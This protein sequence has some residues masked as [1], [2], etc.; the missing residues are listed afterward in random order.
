MVVNFPCVSM[1]PVPPSLLVPSG[2]A[3]LAQRPPLPW[4]IAQALPE[5]SPGQYHSRPDLWRTAPAPFGET[6][7]KPG[8]TL[9]ALGRP[10]IRSSCPPAS[11]SPCVVE[12]GPA[13]PATLPWL[14]PVS[15]CTWIS[16]VLAVAWEAQSR[17]PGHLQ[18]RGKRSARGR[19]RSIEKQASTV[20]WR[21][22]TSWAELG[23][24]CPG[25]A[26]PREELHLWA[27][28]RVRRPET[29]ETPRP[30]HQCGKAQLLCETWA[31]RR[32]SKYAHRKVA[33]QTTV[34]CSRTQ[35]C[36]NLRVVMGGSAVLG[37]QI[38]LN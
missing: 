6:A 32:F 13:R 23:S 29:L 31:R 16:G 17:S 8:S 27:E 25:R 18:G 36:P 26:R 28:R 5:K 22:A 9:S 11:V 21:P 34:V 24:R 35:P 15:A 20:A 10:E 4:I 14:E 37:I 2:P 30:P 12:S 7:T 1:D 38:D 19:A 33:S 3:R